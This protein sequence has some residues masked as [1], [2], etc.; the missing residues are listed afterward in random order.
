LI[1]IRNQQST[2][3]DA[4]NISV[5]KARITTKQVNLRKTIQLQRTLSSFLKK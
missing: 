1:S 3:D 2:G 4:K 5:W